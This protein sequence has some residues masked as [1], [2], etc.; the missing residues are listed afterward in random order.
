PPQEAATHLM[1]SIKQSAQPVLDQGKDAVLSIILDGENAWE[2]YPQSGREFLRRF[3]DALQHEPGVE[4][5]TVSDAIQRHRDFGHPSAL[6]RPTTLSSQLWPAADVPRFFTKVPT[7]IL[8][9]PAIWCVISSGWVRRSIPPTTAPARCM[10][11][12]F[13]SIRFMPESTRKTFTDA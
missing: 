1:R 5:V 4:A 8:E 3:Y 7:F 9:S 6:A 2:Y 13:F 10:A 11:N 12:N